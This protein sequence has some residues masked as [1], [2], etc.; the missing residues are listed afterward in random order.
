MREEIGQI[1]LF[2]R[3]WLG[4]Q[5]NAIDWG[6]GSPPPQIILE[7]NYR[8][9]TIESVFITSSRDILNQCLTL[10]KSS[11]RVRS[12][13]KCKKSVFVVLALG[14][15]IVA[16]KSSNSPKGLLYI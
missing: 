6:G 8:S 15:I 14:S 7:I 12:Q 11:S 2:T 13:V 4:Y 3:Y 10:L 16:A 5:L 1:R 9:E